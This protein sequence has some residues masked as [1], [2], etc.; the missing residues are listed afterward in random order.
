MSAIVSAKG[1]VKRY[2]RTVAVAGIDLDVEAGEIFGLVGPNG[3]GK[4]TTLRMLA[5]L[6]RPTDGDAEIAGASVRGR[7]RRG[8]PRHRLHA[9]RLRRLRRHEGLGVPRLLRPLLRP[10][11]GPP[12]ADDRRPARARRP[13]RQARHVRPGPVARDAAAAVP[14]PR[15]RPRSGGA[16][17][18]RAGVRPRP[19]GAG[20]AARA[21]ARAALARQDDRDPQPHPAR[22]RGAVHRASRSSTAARSSPRAGSPTSSGG[23]ASGRCSGSGCSPRAKRSR[24]RGR[25]SRPTSDVATAHVLDDGDDRD[26]VP[27][28]RRRLGP[29]PRARPSR[30]GCRSS[31]F[32]RAASDLEE[33]FLQVTAPA[34]LAHRSRPR[35]GAR[36]E[37]LAASIRRAGA[38]RSAG[39]FGGISAIGGEGA[40][41]PDA[42]AA[43]VRRP[44][45]LPARPG[46]LR[47][48]A[49]ERSRRAR[50]RTRASA[51]R[52]T[53]SAQIG[54]GH[55]RRAAHPRRRCSSLFLAPAFTTGAISLEREKQT[56]DLLVTTPDLVARRSSSASSSARCA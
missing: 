22:A 37:R 36:H 56:L 40:A 29:A 44:D 11:G 19:A 23:S 34:R 33:L 46:R 42:R 35:R 2:D 47:L 55:L 16:A 1:L 3:A 28:R 41:R 4:T 13:R 31:R 18:R 52:P 32:A 14:R 50:S 21:P 27:G 51:A 8:P 24:R 17:P 10:A 30:P 53:Q 54:T 39:R 45:L 9:R 25:T 5:T 26:R 43:G 48:D 38:A 20:R 6:L 15:A 12:A 7:P 49:R